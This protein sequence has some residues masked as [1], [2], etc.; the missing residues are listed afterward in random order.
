MRSWK[1][2]PLSAFAGYGLAGCL[3]GNAQAALDTS[4][5]LVRSRSTSYTGARMREWQKGER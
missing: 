3:L 4:I 1:A 5:D 2:A